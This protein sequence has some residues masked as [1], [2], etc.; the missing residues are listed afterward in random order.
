[1]KIACEEI[2]DMKLNDFLPL[3]AKE[4]LPAAVNDQEKALLVVIDMQNDFMDDGALPVPGAYEDVKRLTKWMYN[5]MLKITKIAV[6]LDTHIPHQIFHPCWWVDEN[7]TNPP[8]FTP[9][10]L[11]DLDRGKWR[12]VL[13]PEDSRD[14]VTG[15][16]TKGLSVLLVW[17]YHCIQGTHGAALEA[18]FAN[19][20]YFHEVAKRSVPIHLVKGTDPLSEMYGIIKPEYD[21]KNFVNTAFLNLFEIYDKIVVA[22]QAKTHCVFRS[23]QQILEHYQDRPGILKKFYILE[24]CMSSIPGFNVDREFAQFEGGYQVHL[25]KS[26]QFEL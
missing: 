16:K 3:A 19:M 5:N 20:L 17:P 6:S 11:D 10:T 24:D 25:V 4:S 8:P 15:L 14:Y 12:A 22:G 2:V 1:M 23:V 7:G 26:T 9:I 21:K 13:N 18:Q